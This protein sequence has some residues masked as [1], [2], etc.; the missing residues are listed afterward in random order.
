MIDPTDLL[1]AA[2]RGDVETCKLL[3]S[4]G[5][6]VNDEAGVGLPLCLAADKGQLEI[7]R[8]LINAGA[9]VSRTGPDDLSALMHASRRG[10][11]EVCYLL[12]AAGACP[13]QMTANEGS[14]L[15]MAGSLC[16]GSEARVLRTLLHHPA[17][18]VEVPSERMVQAASHAL[19]RAT[20][21]GDKDSCQ[22]LISAGAD[23]NFVSES[24]W[25][26]L[27]LAAANDH[28]L[29]CKLLLESGGDPSLAG[30]CSRNWPLTPFQVAVDMGAASVV[31]HFLGH[32]DENP[33]Q[34][35]GDG[36]TMSKL[37]AKRR[38]ILDLLESARLAAAIGEAVD[39]VEAGAPAPETRKRSTEPAL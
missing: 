20:V 8:L 23:V 3:L 9:D 13:D 26:S 17:G 1:Y 30:L 28:L 25:T 39:G 34:C 24:G 36:R 14:A 35:T 15:T 7:C 4:K 2:S 22:M 33:D 11:A 6:D 29:V 31:A 32:L 16:E 19:I 5:A 37:A 21:R 38:P 18:S 10:H 27:H 12:M